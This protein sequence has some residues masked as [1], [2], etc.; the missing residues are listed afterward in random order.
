LHLREALAQLLNNPI[1]LLQQ[2]VSDG[3]D[4]GV[5]AVSLL[6]TSPER[7]LHPSCNC[8]R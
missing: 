4:F 6:L 8:R 3:E 5:R 2:L 7:L 1:Q